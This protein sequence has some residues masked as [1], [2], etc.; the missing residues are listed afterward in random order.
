MANKVMREM[1]SNQ[2]AFRGPI[3][4]HHNEAQTKGLENVPLW[5]KKHC[6]G[7]FNELKL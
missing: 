7:D 4:V 5:L 6:F 2:S 1:G 3:Y